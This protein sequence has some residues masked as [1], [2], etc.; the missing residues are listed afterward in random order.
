[1]NAYPHPVFVYFNGMKSP[2]Q[3]RVIEDTPLVDLI[4]KPNT[5]LWYP[6]NQRVVK[7]EYRSP[8]FDNIRKI[9]FTNFE[10]KTDEHL[11]FI[12]SIFHYYASKGLIEVDV[13]ITWSVKD[14]INMLQCPQLPVY[15]NI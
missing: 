12:S 3:F 5:L 15:N 10:L 6:K 13:K 9:Q 14:I 11:K 2:L 8:S 1:M 4:S 7:L